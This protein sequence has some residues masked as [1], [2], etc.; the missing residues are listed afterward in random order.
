MGKS[1]GYLSHATWER[2]C[3]GFEMGLCGHEGR[4]SDARQFA[5]ARCGYLAARA[6]THE[7]QACGVCHGTFCP[8]KN[9]GDMYITKVVV[10][11]AY[12]IVEPR[13]DADLRRRYERFGSTDCA[14]ASLN[15]EQYTR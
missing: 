4:R 6:W 13:C 11:I 12:T 2:V 7:L 8:G 15:A 9:S 14:T 10:D 1:T 5:Y 3:L